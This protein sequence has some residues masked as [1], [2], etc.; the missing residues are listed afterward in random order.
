MGSS[1]HVRTGTAMAAHPVTSRREGAERRGERDGRTSMSQYAADAAVSQAGTAR[2]S[3]CL[4]RPRPVSRAAGRQAGPRSD[5]GGGARAHRGSGRG[6]VSPADADDSRAVP[7]SEDPD[8]PAPAPE[9]SGHDHQI[10]AALFDLGRQGRCL[11][12]AQGQQAG[13]RAPLGEPFGG[14]L[15]DGGGMLGEELLPMLRRDCARWPPG[16]RRRCGQRRRHR[17]VALR[18]AGE[19]D[20]MRQRRVITAPTVDEAHHSGATSSHVD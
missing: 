2:R 1:H 11:D 20:R 5:A 17:Q 13:A 7:A 16:S 3:H 8:E 19:L 18:I 6:L 15:Q 4:C 9:P 14:V 10:E 12:S